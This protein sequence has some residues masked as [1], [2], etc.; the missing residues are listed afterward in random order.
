MR[1]RT[2]IVAAF[3][4][5]AGV[6]VGQRDEIWD[7]SDRRELASVLDG[8]GYVPHPI[9]D[10]S[11]ELYREGLVPLGMAGYY[12]RMP[13]S[14]NLEPARCLDGAL[15]DWWEGRDTHRSPASGKMRG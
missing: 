13:R 3:A 15:P 8:C 12:T 11:W 1:I 14:V 9:S 6:L 2:A 10:V 5:L 4:L 7:R